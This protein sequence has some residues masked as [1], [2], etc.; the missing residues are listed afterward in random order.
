MTKFGSTWMIFEL[1]CGKGKFMALLSSMLLLAMFLVSCGKSDPRLDRL[2]SL[3]IQASDLPTGWQREKGG[4][5]DRDSKD[6][7][8]I[9]RWVQFRGAPEKEILGVLVSQELTDYPDI[10]Q[11]TS[12]YAEIV[13]EI[14][15]VEDWTWP[16][17]VV[18]VSQADQFRLA[19]FEQYVSNYD[20]QRL[21]GSYYCRAIGQYGTTISVIYANV[22][23]DQWLTFEDLQHLL[24]AADA[25]L[26]TGTH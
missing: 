6:E 10:D 3:R 13:K 12:A 24:E 4:I 1:C 23:Q 9:S 20:D 25:R 18:L 21:K 16:E 17:Q 15:P 14:F 26:A 2:F 19:C 5:G 11:A 22:F 8:V 7:G